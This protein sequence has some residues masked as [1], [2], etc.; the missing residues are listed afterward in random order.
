M[1]VTF[2]GTPETSLVHP[3]PTKRRLSS[4][5]PVD[6]DSRVQDL[7]MSVTDTIEK[8][9]NTSMSVVDVPFNSDLPLGFVVESGST[10]YAVY[11]FL[12][13]T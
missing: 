8:V 4:T 13:S 10:G 7:K 3:S 11:P 2:L 5:A 9:L 6:D 1:A 12:H